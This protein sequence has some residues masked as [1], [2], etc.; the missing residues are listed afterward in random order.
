MTLSGPLR[1]LADRIRDPS[2][3]TLDE[4]AG[5]TLEP[6]AVSLPGV[7]QD[8]ARP[9]LAA[10]TRLAGRYRIER[11]LG[12]GGSGEVYA[13]HDELLGTRIAV[14]LLRGHPGATAIERLRAEILS[15]RRVTHP[16]LCKVFDLTRSD[17]GDDDRG[18]GGE[19]L[20][21]LT[22]EL[23]DGASLAHHLASAGPLTAADANRV[24]LELVDAV[25]AAHA[26]GVIHRDLS[27]GNVMLVRRDG[28]WH[29]VVTDFG[30][31]IAV[32]TAAPP[33][34]LGAGTPA[35]M[36]PEQRA[37]RP[38]TAASDVWALGVVL[39]ELTTGRRPEAG[40]PP[41][42]VPRRWGPILR[43]CLRAEPS[44]RFRDA[45][46]LAR[47]LRGRRR[48]PAALALG[49]TAVAAVLVAIVVAGGPDPPRPLPPVP[50]DPAPADGVRRAFALGGNRSTVSALHELP[51]GDLLLTG[52]AMA[53]FAPR[54]VPIAGCDP[55]R[56]C[57]YV[58]RSSPAGALR[59]VRVLAGSGDVRLHAAAVGDA[60]VVIA[61]DLMGAAAFA[62][63][64]GRDQLDGFVAE[65]ALDGGRTRWFHRVG[66]AREASL[67]SVARAGDGAVY[68]AGIVN[69]DDPWRRTWPG[70]APASATALVMA[71]AP[72]GA[73]GW[74]RTLTTSGSL[75]VMDVEVVGD[76]VVWGGSAGGEVHGDQLDLAAS[77]RARA[78]I[79]AL[80]RASGQPRW[81]VAGRDGYSAVG[82][83]AGAGPDALVAAGLFEG[84]ATLG[85]HAL[86]AQEHA[87]GWLARVELAT[88]RVTWL[89]R[90]GGPGWGNL[91]D[92]L[93]RGDDVYAVGRCRG[94]VEDGLELR[95]RGLDDALLIR[96]RGDGTLVGAWL[97][98]DVDGD[99]ARR[100]AAAAGGG[101]W[102]GG[103]FRHSFRAGRY[104]LT[105]RG[106]E[107]A[108]VIELA[109]G[110]VTGGAP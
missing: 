23:L 98:G 100:V 91:N 76:L 1:K 67:R 105:G 85:D 61:G 54:G 24:G 75:A 106:Q 58:A 31:A 37:G 84:S 44:R 62:D 82:A 71:L 13:A 97:W 38:P 79:E 107:S 17:D 4:D 5:A 18:G 52:H 65:L 73:P 81:L 45:S 11:R 101:L 9:R 96:A 29:G 49:G 39:A 80:D 51:G 20:W 40:E 47:A 108:F 26:A 33:P 66:V 46:E 12:I 68:V 72:D 36:P 30:L 74:R 43:R 87:D 57:G 88:G 15:A 7:V 110:A 77:P 41:A 8:P 92:V 86:T 70:A 78:L 53:P 83:L 21:F 19:P 2:E 56:R 90:V 34:A 14:K 64:R 63:D 6:D 48:W 50:V 69:G 59:W 10:G 35:Y 95:G 32:D 22:M 104:H 28:A 102:V 94:L 3:G 60:R 93:V 55:G 27:T 16:A 42:G 25:A 89:R 103:S 109:A 99:K